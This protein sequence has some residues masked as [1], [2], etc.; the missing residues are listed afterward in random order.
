M[1]SSTAAEEISSSAVS[2]ESVSRSNWWEDLCENG[3]GEEDDD[4]NYG[5]VD[6]QELGRALSEAASLASHSK[7]Q[8][9]SIHPK[10]VAN[11]LPVKPSMVVKDACIPGR[12]AFYLT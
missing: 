6:L 10:D 12:V 9:G 5:A 2:C 4:D 7:K 1:E 8:N 11:G 3:S